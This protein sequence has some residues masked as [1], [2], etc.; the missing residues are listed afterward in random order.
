MILLILET[1]LNN[2][3]FRRGVLLSVETS[4]GLR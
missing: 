4:L 1:L 2:S 3:L